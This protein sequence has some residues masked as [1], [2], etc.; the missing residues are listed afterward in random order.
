MRKPPEH[1]NNP[2]ER[3][4]RLPCRRLTDVAPSN[5]DA[6]SRPR[7][8]G[9]AG[10][11]EKSSPTVAWVGVL[12]LS[13]VQHDARRRPREL[14]RQRTVMPPDAADEGVEF[15]DGLKGDVVSEEIRAAG[16]G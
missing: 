9:R 16:G 4:E 15:S 14:L 10:R 12:R 6:K 5:G 1:A 13:N 2:V 8:I 11:R 3:S 7:L